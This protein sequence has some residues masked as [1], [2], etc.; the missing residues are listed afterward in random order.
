MIKFDVRLLVVRLAH[1]ENFEKELRGHMPPEHLPTEPQMKALGQPMWTSDAP[2]AFTTKSGR[3]WIWATIGPLLDELT[4]LGLTA[5]QLEIHHI[6]NHADRWTR[7]QLA[8]GFAAL[9]WKIQQELNDR[10]FLYLTG[11]EAAQ[12]QSTQ[13]FGELVASTF[14]AAVNTELCE[15]SKCLAV[16]RY[17]ACVFHLMHVMEVAVRV[18]GKKLRVD[19]VKSAPAGK[20]VRELSWDQILNALNPKLRALPQNT[21]K[22]KRRHEKFSA[23]QSY[24]YGV[25]DAWR[26]PTMHPRLEGY[27]ELQAKDIM[28][29]VR[30]FL[31]EFAPLIKGR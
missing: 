7:I 22:Q 17:T 13:P 24:L 6:W 31:T 4:P 15:A 5:A 30:S 28:N 27:N 14:P 9:R 2:E 3:D 8:D 19:I 1:L 26:N 16:G 11:E 23:A 12:F 29:H 10:C 18:F 21:E 25:K 20:R